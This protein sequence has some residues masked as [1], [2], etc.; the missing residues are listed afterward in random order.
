LRHQNQNRDL[1]TQRKG[2]ENDVAAVSH[3][4]GAP[5]FKV[6]QTD[7][8]NG[9]VSMFRSS[10]LLRIIFLRIT[11][12]ALCLIV[13][14]AQAYDGRSPVIR[15]DKGIKTS[16]RAADL[17]LETL[18]PL[19][20]WEIP[21]G[22]AASIERD[23]Q[24][25]ILYLEATQSLNWALLISPKADFL[26]QTSARLPVRFQYQGLPNERVCVFGSFNGWNR[27]AHILEETALG[28][29]D[30]HTSLAP[31]DHQYLFVV[32]TD[33]IRDPANPDSVGNGFGGWNSRLFLEEAKGEPLR[34]RRLG[35]D[36][37]DGKRR[38][39]FLSSSPQ[40]AQGQLSALYGNRTLAEKSIQW[41]GDTLTLALPAAPECGPAILRVGYTLGEQQAPLQ[42]I[43]LEDAFRWEDAVVYSIMPDRFRNGNP[44]ND[45]PVAHPELL[46]PANWQGG[47]LAGI[48]QTLDEGYFED[49]GVNA[50]W[51]Y[52]VNESTDLAWK[53]FPEPHRFYTGYHGYWPTHPTRI[54]SR[55]GTDQDL[56]SLVKDLHGKDLR[57]IMDLVANHVHVEHPWVKDHPEW[58]GQLE[59]PDGRKN[60]RIWD[61]HRL[62]TWFEPYMPDIDY[63]SSQAA[64]DAMSEVGLYWLE[65]FDL[66]GFRH[67]AVKHV[68]RSFWN[69]MTAKLDRPAKT[70]PLYQIGE[71]FG[72][73]ELIQS[74]ISPAAM[75]A[76]FNFNLF[77][78]AR[79]IFLDEGRG[80][81]ELAGLIEQNLRTYGPN[82]LMG[83]LMD[84]HDKARYAGFAD[85]DLALTGENLQERGW[86][87]P[88]HVDHPSTYRKLQL[89]MTYMLGLPGVP[90]IYYGDEIGM[91][92]AA[93]PD[94]RRMMRFGSDVRP[95]ENWLLDETSKL[96]HM[97]RERPELRRGDLEILLADDS[98]LVWMRSAEA[99]SGDASRCLIVLNKS[100][101]QQNRDLTLPLSLGK[102]SISLAPWE[103]R[104][105]PLD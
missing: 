12:F 19:L 13:L 45:Q 7:G 16:F 102:K 90:F 36:S 104:F 105:I 50:L 82:H 58:F 56:K 67:D 43:F 47:D 28:F 37:V 66:D 33:E 32:G 101:T 103:G 15:L 2:R 5:D 94:N 42:T 51:L 60:L 87:N 29:Y 89:Y 96:I 20:E 23:G 100:G 18:P 25:N 3:F 73:N 69:A 64:I 63:V 53:E 65:T 72:S 24:E 84:S 30:L 86:D 74:Y 31:G 68:P 40:A 46:V 57:I 8:S 35:W 70:R 17:G 49:L 95:D 93:D 22:L 44:D 55:F 14:P 71:T 52:P 61:E 79:E 10:S 88:P 76:Q 4:E 1:S 21:E 11:L 80:F 92:G 62:T 98:V 48:Q 41:E 83:N 85:G 59:L 27:G 26:L 6:A 91:S 77:H 39:R 75:D 81:K 99:P 54:D 9:E 97:R 78:P 38:I 34:L